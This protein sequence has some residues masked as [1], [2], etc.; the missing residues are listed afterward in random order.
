MPADGAN[1]SASHYNVRQTGLGAVPIKTLF[2]QDSYEFRRFFLLAIVSAGLMFADARVPQMALVRSALAVAVM[3]FHLVAN[4]P[5]RTV[6][7][8]DDVFSTRGELTEE[9][10]RLNSR[11]LVLEGK[12]QKLVSLEA[13]NIRLRELLNASAALDETV[14]I[15]E[16]VAVDPDPFTHRVIINR[17][18]AHGVFMGQPVLDAKGLMGQVVQIDP[19]MSRVLLVTDASHAIPVQVGRNGLRAVAVGTSRTQRLELVHVPDTAD[20]KVGDTL[21]SSGMGLRFPPGYPVAVV[22]SIKHDPGRPFARVEATTSAEL[23][24]S[25]YV[26]LVFTEERPQVAAGRPGADQAPVPPA[27]VSGGD[28]GSE[29]R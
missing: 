16:V 9:N 22:H 27:E 6:R 1:A 20:I 24:R 14:L 12:V 10:A 7:W 13:E 5:V 2:K 17:G 19:Y 11:V 29:T 18:A 23:D 3:P 28:G 26:L 4:A 8:F 21:F 15:A 25:R